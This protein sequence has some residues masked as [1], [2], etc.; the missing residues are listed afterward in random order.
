MNF[1]ERLFRLRA[2]YGCEPTTALMITSLVLSAASTT[3]SLV[4]QKKQA[5]AQADYQENL[6]EANVKAAQV[7]SAQVRDQQAQ[8]NE[9]T[10]R[11]SQ[12]ASLASRKASSTATVAAGEAGVSGNSVDALLRDYRGQEGIFKEAVL[13][14]KQLTDVSAGQQI[15]AIRSGADAGNLSMNAPIGQPNYLAGALSFGAQAAST[16]AL[17]KKDAPP[18]P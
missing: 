12:Q 2:G 13:R 15:D 18:K 4:G 1:S 3:A 7:Q 9:A 16:Y 6:A 17:S 10:T 5:D 14:Q 11:E 8:A